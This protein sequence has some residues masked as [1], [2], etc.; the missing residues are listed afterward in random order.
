LD[1]GKPL[2]VI[3]SELGLRFEAKPAVTGDR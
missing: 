3:R 1:C 2:S